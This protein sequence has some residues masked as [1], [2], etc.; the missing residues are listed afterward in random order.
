MA[1]IML[2]VDVEERRSLRTEAAT[3]DHLTCVKGLAHGYFLE[4]FDIGMEE[5]IIVFW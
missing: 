1:E 2:P 4:M 5:G 3:G